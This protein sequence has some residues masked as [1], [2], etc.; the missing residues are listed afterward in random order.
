VIRLSLFVTASMAPNLITSVA[1]VYNLL[2]NGLLRLRMR[3]FQST[4]TRGVVRAVPVPKQ[5][6]VSVTGAWSCII[7]YSM[8]VS[9][10]IRGFGTEIGGKGLYRGGWSYFSVLHFEFA[11]SLRIHEPL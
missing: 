6:V 4:P 5:R 8:M 11:G 3:A 1:S 9:L 10:R 7:I 2:P